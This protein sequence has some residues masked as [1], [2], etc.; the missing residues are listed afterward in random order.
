M[1]DLPITLAALLVADGCNVGLTPVTSESAP[2]LTR[3]RLSHVDQNYVHAS[4]YQAYRDG[5]D[6]THGR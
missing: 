4:I 3:A 5:A 2:A 6:V 1:D